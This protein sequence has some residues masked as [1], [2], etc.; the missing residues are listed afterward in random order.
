MEL[1]SEPGLW[2]CLTK[3]C[4]TKQLAWG[5][6]RL[7][8]GSKLNGDPMR[9][10]VSQR[11]FLPTPKQVV[12]MSHPAKHR[13]FGGAAGPGKSM[14]ARWMLYRLCMEIPG[15]EAL[16]LRENFPELDR[17]H[18][19]RMAVECDLI[20]AEFIESK[21]VMRFPQTKSLIEC[22]HM[23]DDKAL[24]RYL[25]TEYDHIIP[26]EASRYDP[27]RLLELSTRARTSK[28]EVLRRGGARFDPVSN[29]G[30]PAAQMLDDLFIKKQLDPDIYPI[31]SKVDE[32]GEPFYKP[33]EW[34]YIP[35]TLDDNPYLDPD[36]P[37]TLARLQPWRYEQLRHG[38]WDVF[39]GQFFNWNPRLHVREF[40]VVRPDTAT[41]FRSLDWGYHDPTVVLWWVVLPDGHLHIAGELKLKEHTIDEVVREV[42][43]MDRTLGLP[44]PI[45]AVRTYAD[46]N[47]RQRQGQTGEAILETFGK[48]KMPL[49]PAVNERKNGWMRVQA[50]LRTAPDGAPWLTVD[51]MCKYLVRSM[52]RCMSKEDDPDEIDLTDD[53]ALD[54]LRYGAMSRPMPQYDKSIEKPKPGMAGHFIDEILSQQTTRPVLGSSAV[55]HG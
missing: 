36:Y 16:I 43:A 2:W 5:V 30:G 33:E 34:T 26:D 28:P 20:G 13:L 27:N 37:R 39:A 7:A 18:L 41:W 38:N 52:A 11:L 49:I 4:Y 21:R 23:D 53:H 24:A 55:M 54:S 17:T 6:S 1:A 19:R 9:K 40:S 31:L 35:A 42:Q 51:P 3:A 12:F 45:S 29:P 22:G 44:S 32:K 14:A 10:R 25:S 8:P 50:L 48:C 15:Y 46:P 47:T